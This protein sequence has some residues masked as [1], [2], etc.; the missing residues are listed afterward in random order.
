M[1]GST[2]KVLLKLASG[3][4]ALLLASIVA[5]MLYLELADLATHRQ[6]IQATGQA[7]LGREVRL[8]GEVRLDFRRTL[9]VSAQR[10]QIGNPEWLD[11]PWMLEL[12]DASVGL[13]LWSLIRG[14][15]RFKRIH[16]GKGKMLVHRHET[17]GT[18]WHF[19][20]GNDQ[21]NAGRL[22]AVP[23]IIEQ[24]DAQGLDI[25]LRGPRIPMG[26]NLGISSFNIHRADADILLVA[27]TGRLEGRPWKLGGSLGTLASLLSGRD[28]RLDISLEGAG[29]RL[30]FRGALESLSEFQELDASLTA[31]GDALELITGTFGL[32]GLARGPYEIFLTARDTG[33]AHQVDFDM[34]AG[35]FSADMAL[36]LSGAFTGAM[37]TDVT[38]HVRG[39]DFGALADI[40][41]IAG[42]AREPFT[43]DGEFH[44]DGTETTFRHLILASNQNSLSV[45][46]RV[47][48]APDYLGT[49]L[50]LQLDLEDVAA[51]AR[52]LGIGQFRSRPLAATATLSHDTGGLTLRQGRVAL[53][54]D[55]L[56][57]SGT[58]GNL[59]TLQG[60]EMDFSAS[61]TDLQALGQFFDADVLPALPVEIT[62]QLETTGD[63]IG[64]SWLKILSAGAE[65]DVKGTLGPA[66]A[67]NHARLELALKLDDMH[68]FGERTAW[69]PPL[70]AQSLSG[71]AVLHLD[72]EAARFS[73]LAL[74]SPLA[75]LRG[76]VLVPLAGAGLPVRISADAKGPDLRALGSAASIDFLPE[77]PFHSEAQLEVYRDRVHFSRWQLSAGSLAMNTSNS[78]ITFTQ[79]L[80]GSMLRAEASGGDARTLHPRLADLADQPIPFEFLARV[81]PQAGAL[82]I[83]QLSGQVAGVDFDTRGQLGLAEDLANTDL[84]FSLSSPSLANT[85][86]SLLKDPVPDVPARASGNLLIE[87]DGY[88]ARDVQAEVGEDRLTVQAH[89]K[90]GTPHQAH[91]DIDSDALDLD[92]VVG[93]WAL[94]SSNEP[95]APV[96]DGRIIPDLALPVAWLERLQGNASINIR[97]LKFRNR[98][99]TRVTASGVADSGKL[100]LGPL[101]AVFS[102]GSLEASINGEV[103]NDEL[104]VVLAVKGQDIR[105]GI[106]KSGI[107]MS[108][109]PPSDIAAQLGGHGS[110]LRE[111][112]ATASGPITLAIGRGIYDDASALLTSDVLTQVVAAFNPFTQT[113][114]TT[115]FECGIAVLN[116]EQGIL[117]S[118]VIMLQTRPTLTGAVARIDLRTE[119][120]E[121]IFNVMVR[122]GI[123]LSM[124]SIANPYIK[125]GGTLGNPN[126]TFAPTRAAISYGA[127]VAT[128]GLSIVLKGFLDRLRSGGQVCEAELKKRNLRLPGTGD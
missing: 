81:Q 69:L 13:D 35:E 52:R 74:D 88:A 23:L 90:R 5:L 62:G 67:P 44:H 82:H 20:D 3:L 22:D 120:I 59:A 48:S 121:V 77:L 24:M 63:G 76:D 68:A 34:R 54:P 10:L 118:Q 8:E 93:L 21:Q 72:K 125:I 89:Y 114:A 128:G 53:G 60:G 37:A 9:T 111:L 12:E 70:P 39:P 4:V 2:V 95:A 32:P 112:A 64:L 16:V 30:E 109:R 41:G 56:R 49:S 116:A 78:T 6:L 27:S 100:S 87:A 58:L 19:K 110:T 36:A 1:P 29:V 66:S 84:Q 113:E 107:D 117:E 98:L 31:R 43:L 47:G 25:L 11:D 103:V 65:L 96:D 86:G 99:F 104:Q 42:L 115:A 123:G 105:P 18:N 79:G 122:Q 92:R 61:V 28:L 108:E 55:V 38:A 97:E 33:T 15:L 126:L 71:S 85:I 51:V 26:V 46:G 14:P 40:L 106:V 83:Q 101:R 91:L 102:G 45:H 124:S 75:G 73:D 57:A 94:V 7:L 17:L 119:K 80:A 127:A 50:E